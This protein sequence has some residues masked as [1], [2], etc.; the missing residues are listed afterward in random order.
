MNLLRPIVPGPLVQV[1]GLEVRAKERVL[2]S[3]IDL[4]VNAGEI[5]TV[6]GPNGAGKTTLIRA[7]LGLVAPSHGTVRVRPGAAIGYVPQRVALSRNLP[8]TVERFVALSGRTEAVRR[9]AVLE[10]VGIG[11][12]AGSSIHDVSGGEF[13]RALLARAL[14][15][16]PALLVLDEPAQAV[17]ITGQTELYALIER[18]RDERGCGILMVSHDLHLVMSGSDQVVCINRHLCCAGQPETVSRHPE[19]IA[20]FGP[21]AARTL[22][23]YQHRHDHTHDL[24]GAAHNEHDHAHDHDG[25]RHG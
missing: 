16:D 8:L 15:R 21:E 7:V 13:Q 19:Y 14:L 12:L 17:D 11:S 1:A 5:V 23:L 10:E 24:H 9:R 22:A 20:L 18:L 3:G 6:I 25:H 4:T 2:L